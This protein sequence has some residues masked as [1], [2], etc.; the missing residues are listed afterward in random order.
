MN[1]DFLLDHEN[2]QIYQTV[3]KRKRNVGYGPKLTAPFRGHDHD[4]FT[5][6]ITPHPEY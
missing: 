6:S 4:L 2:K 1:D 5:R 3:E